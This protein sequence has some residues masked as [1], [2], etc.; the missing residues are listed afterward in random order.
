MPA[1]GLFSVWGAV[2]AVTAAT[3]EPLQK[4]GAVVLVCIAHSTEM[5][6]YFKG[7][8]VSFRKIR[9]MNFFEI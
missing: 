9:E 2:W 8:H 5:A 6:Y 1:R 4:G 3:A 7:I